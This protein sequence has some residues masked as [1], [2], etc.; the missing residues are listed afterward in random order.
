MGGYICLL[1]MTQ[2]IQVENTILFSVCSEIELF[3]KELNGKMPFFEC[4]CP[5]LKNYLTQFVVVLF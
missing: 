2:L 1:S 3:C 5:C 4:N